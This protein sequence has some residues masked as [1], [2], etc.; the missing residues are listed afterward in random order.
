MAIMLVLLCFP[1][2]VAQTLERVLAV[3][4]VPSLSATVSTHWATVSSVSIQK[5]KGTHDARMKK[6]VAI[7]KVISSD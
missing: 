6:T 1:T 7:V 2:D 5:W 4:F 3:D